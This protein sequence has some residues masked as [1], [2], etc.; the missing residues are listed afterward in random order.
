MDWVS[1]T[2]WETDWETDW[3]SETGWETDWGWETDPG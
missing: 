1:E 2:G 3:V